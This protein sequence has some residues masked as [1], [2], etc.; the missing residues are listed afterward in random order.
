MR[1]PS[2]VCTAGK[3]EITTGG[4]DRDREA[5]YD[6]DQRDHENEEEHRGRGFADDEEFNEAEDEQDGRQRVIDDRGASGARRLDQLDEQQD[7]RDDRHQVADRQL[8]NAAGN[9]ADAEKL[10]IEHGPDGRRSSCK[11][12]EVIEDNRHKKP[13]YAEDHRSLSISDIQ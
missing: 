6:V 5:G 11:R 3:S 9:Q 2:V 10:A 1:L 4:A 8:P 7:E 12:N 13:W